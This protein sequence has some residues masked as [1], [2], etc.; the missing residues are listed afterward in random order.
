MLPRCLLW[1]LLKLGS[2]C[3]IWSLLAG[4]VLV[5][6]CQRSK[7]ALAGWYNRLAGLLSYKAIHS[8]IVDAVHVRGKLRSISAEVI[9]LHILR[10]RI[11]HV[12]PLR[13]KSRSTQR[14]PPKYYTETP[15]MPSLSD[16]NQP[17]WVPPLSG[18]SAGGLQV[19]PPLRAASSRFH[20]LGWQIGPSSVLR[21]PWRTFTLAP[22][23][24]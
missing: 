12:R 7:A 10:R 6:R 18:V 15:P 3:L 14:R 23:G 17:G 11:H 8:L 13:R 5:H 24:S 22:G 19:D 20:V 9:L 4:H 2:L 21:R 16:Q 1:C